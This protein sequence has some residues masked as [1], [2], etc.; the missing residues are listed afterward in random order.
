MIVCAYVSISLPASLVEEIAQALSYCT[1]DEQITQCISCLCSLVRKM[2]L[3]LSYNGELPFYEGQK[4]G[5]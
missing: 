5:A 4:N 3:I 1:L 2:K